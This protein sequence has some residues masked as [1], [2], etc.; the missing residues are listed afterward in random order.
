MMSMK[1]NNVI[2]WVLKAASIV[3]SCLFPIIAICD[4]FPVWT[5]KHGTGRSIGT[6]GILIAIVLLVI[7]RKTVFDFIKERLKLNHAPPLV[8]WIVMLII[9]YALLYVCKFLTDII[10][11]FWMGFLGCGL[12]TLITMVA[13]VCFGKDT[14]NDEG[15]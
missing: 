15:T 10:L 6:G 2:Y 1:K 14:E 7:F 12:G 3:I 5:E 13:E 11:V 4:K 8:V 9:G